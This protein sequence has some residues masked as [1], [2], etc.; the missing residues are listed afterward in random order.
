MRNQLITGVLAVVA[1]SSLIGLGSTARAATTDHTSTDS[2]T[3]HEK[4]VAI[5]CGGEWRGKHVYAEVYENSLHGNHVQVVIDDGAY[6]AERWQD[7]SIVTHDQVRTRVRLDGSRAVVK[8][9]ARLDG[10][11]KHV[12]EVLEDAGQTIES[13]GTQRGLDTNVAFHWKDRAVKLDC[14]ESFRY[15][16]TVTR[17]PVE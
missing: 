7:A 8:G 3:T 6:A 11:R 9:L 14:S 1:T 12:H 10:T 13:T 2:T 4:G 5:S 15:R 16:L 17:T